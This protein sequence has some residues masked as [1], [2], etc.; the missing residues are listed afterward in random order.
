[1]LPPQTWLLTEGGKVS[2]SYSEHLT[3]YVTWG[4]GPLNGVT[5]GKD[6]TRSRDAVM[7]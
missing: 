6:L 3:Q 7:G 2:L 4:T 5:D 1:M